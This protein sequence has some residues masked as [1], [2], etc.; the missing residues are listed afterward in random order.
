MEKLSDPMLDA[1]AQI[2]AAW[3]GWPKDMNAIEQARYS[4]RNSEYQKICA[5]LLVAESARQTDYLRSI[6]AIP[7]K[8]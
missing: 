1:A 7:E 3:S 4:I 6:G 2:I 8:G 5:R